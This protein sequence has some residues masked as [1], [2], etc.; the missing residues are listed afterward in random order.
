MLIFF[1]ENEKNNLRKTVYDLEQIKQRNRWLSHP[2][3]VHK[4]CLLMLNSR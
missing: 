3:A 1:R 2:W 4:Q